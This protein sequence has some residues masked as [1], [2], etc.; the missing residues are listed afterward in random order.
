MRIIVISDTHADKLPK[1]LLEDIRKSDLVI[2]AGDFTDIETLKALRQIKEVRAVYGNMD[3]LELRQA[4]P[5]REVFQ[6]EGVRIGI[7]HGEGSSDGMLER[8][9]GHFQGDAVQAI[10]FGHT[11]AA[12]N[13]VIDGVLFFNPGSPTD[14]IRATV[15][16][17]GVLEVHGQ[18]IK[19]RIEKLK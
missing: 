5:Q 1:Q 19:G 13:K 18:E 8:I 15:R 17:Y 10:V 12:M 11:H 2:H 14:H 4:L 7:F 6:C 9:R 16:S 3:G